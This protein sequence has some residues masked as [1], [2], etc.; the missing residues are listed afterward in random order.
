MRLARAQGYECVLGCAYPH[1]P[2]R[3]PAWYIR[4]LVLKN[5]RPGTIVILHDG[6]ADLR[7]SIQAL[8]RILG[9]G[10]E[11]GLRFVSIAKLLREGQQPMDTN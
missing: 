6:I 2:M 9:A 8:P 11:R 7:R 10:R 3:V 5:L 1:D 4:W